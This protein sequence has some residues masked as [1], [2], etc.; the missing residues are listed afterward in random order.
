[1]CVLFAEVIIPFGLIRS[2]EC[3][4]ADHFP[5]FLEGIVD[6]RSIGVRTALRVSHDAGA[7]DNRSDQFPECFV[8]NASPLE[9]GFAND[10]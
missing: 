9:R 8:G 2:S 7:N 6:P 10:R 3:R 4:P 1:M 5:E